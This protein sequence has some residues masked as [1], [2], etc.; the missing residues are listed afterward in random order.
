MLEGEGV[1]DAD[2][3]RDRPH[4]DDGHREQDG[5]AGETGEGEGRALD[6]RHGP[7]G[8]GRR[9]AARH[10]D[11]APPR[12]PSMV[13]RNAPRL[14]SIKNTQRTLAMRRSYSAPMTSRSA[15]WARN[16]RPP[17]EDGR[18]GEVRHREGEDH[19]RRLEQAGRDERQRDGA[20]DLEI[21]GTEVTRAVLE[22]PVEGRQD[23]LD[24]EEGEGKERQGLAHDD[25]RPP[26]D[27]DVGPEGLVDEPAAAPEDDE[28][29]PEHVGGATRGRSATRRNGQRSRRGPRVTA[30]ATAKPMVTARSVTTTARTTLLRR[31]SRKYVVRKNF[32]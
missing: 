18:R 2:E 17:P 8:L 23:V 12:E 27:P 25:A 15:S 28:R 19:H 29:D 7:P 30:R 13:A 31:E 32:A 22:V 11:V 1:V 6:G 5:Q 4:H 9:P 16:A 21:A 20:Q 3:P 26:Q 14:G 24:H 10:R